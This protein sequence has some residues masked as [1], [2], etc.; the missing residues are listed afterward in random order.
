M[1]LISAMKTGDFEIGEMIGNKDLRW[2]FY[3]KEAYIDEVRHNLKRFLYLGY[4][5][6][7][8]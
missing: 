6:D 3:Q 8:Q 5:E 7:V 2:T 1:P 4:F